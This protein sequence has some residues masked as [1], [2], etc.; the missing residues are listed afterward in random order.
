MSESLKPIVNTKLVRIQ[1]ARKPIIGDKIITKNCQK[2]TIGK[3]YLEYEMPISASGIVANFIV[4]CPSILKRETYG[5]AIEP[6]YNNWLVH[7]REYT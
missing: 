6:L 4:N 7:N 3:L 2:G 1:L 5:Q